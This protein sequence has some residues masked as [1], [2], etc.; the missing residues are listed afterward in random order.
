[1][2]STYVHII[3]SI[4]FPQTLQTLKSMTAISQSRGP[5]VYATVKKC[6]SHILTNWKHASTVPSSPVTVLTHLHET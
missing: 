1:M 3:A 5:V 4:G 2:V 6:K